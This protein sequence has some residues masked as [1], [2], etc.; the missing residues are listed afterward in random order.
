MPR[1]SQRRRV[2]FVTGTRAEFGLMQSTLRALRDHP[3]IEL[4]LIATGLHTQRPHRSMLKEIRDGGWKIDAMVPWRE[5][6]SPSG[7]AREMGKVAGTIGRAIRS[8][9]ER[10][11]PHRG[12]PR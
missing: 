4:Q 5:D 12:R 6:A 7:I 9:R 3:R 1:E 8:A 11:H 2:C 10:H